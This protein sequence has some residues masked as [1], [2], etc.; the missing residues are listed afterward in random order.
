M[1]QVHKETRD[2]LEEATGRMKVQYDKRKH[3]AHEYQIGDKVWLDTTNLH[4]PRPKKKLD[5]KRVGPFKILDK[6]GASAYKL[7][8]PPHW[9]I[10]PRFNEKLLTPYTL[11]AFPNQTFPPPLPPELIDSEEEYKVEEI[12]DSHPCM[13][14]GK[15]GQKS[16]K[17]INYFV[18]WKGYTPEHNSRV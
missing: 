6:A 9:K 8:L 5:D 10:H 3:D 13:I 18:K 17:V 14:C 15:W 4:L 12:L 7:K 2:A 16:Q 11:P 1:S